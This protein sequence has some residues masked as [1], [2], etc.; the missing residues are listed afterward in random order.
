MKKAALFTFFMGALTVASFGLFI[1][2]MGGEV[3][4][5]SYPNPHGFKAAMVWFE[6][7]D[8]AE[9]L[10]ENLGPFDGE[11]GRAI[12]SRLDTGNT[13][14][15]IFMPCYSIFFAAIFFYLFKGLKEKGMARPF[16]RYLLFF[17][18]AASLGMWISDIFENRQ[19]LMLTGYATAAGVPGAVLIKLKFWT[20]MKWGLIFFACAIAAV[21]YTRYFSLRTA[22]GIIVALLYASS[23]ATG[24]VGIA[25]SRFRFVIETTNMIIALAWFATIIHAGGIAFA[26]AIDKT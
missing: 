19:L 25:V 13:Y 3:R 22:A 9:E 10:F 8:S 1:V 11:S 5:W 20:T 12:R 18:C 23:A 4:P 24:A 7:T 16:D 15:F 2:K 14:D 17:M 26:R 6:L 21:Q